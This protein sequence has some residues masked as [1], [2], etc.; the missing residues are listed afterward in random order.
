MPYSKAAGVAAACVVAAVATAAPLCFDSTTK[1]ICLDGWGVENGNIT[2][3]ARCTPVAGSGTGALQWCGFGIANATARMWPA[4]VFVLQILSNGE[5]VVEDRHNIAFERPACFA[6]QL[7]YL[8]N[9][10]I[11]PLSG[12]LHAS[13]T[14]PLGLSDAFTSAGYY[15]SE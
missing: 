10:Y 7:S 2:F 15:N 1:N 9:Y 8:T 12:V 5:V 13:W 14:R 6:T 11:D 3:H 4:E